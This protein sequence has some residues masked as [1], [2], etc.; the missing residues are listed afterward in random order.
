MELLN[1]AGLKHLY[2][3]CIKDWWAF[4]FS[5]AI[6]CC[7]SWFWV[8]L[9]ATEERERGFWEWLESEAALRLERLLGAKLHVEVSM[10][11]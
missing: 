10:E 5:R 7:K 1:L 3:T 8:L 6:C 9:E 4:Y 11:C 2:I